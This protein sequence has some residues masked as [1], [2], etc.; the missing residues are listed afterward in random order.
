MARYRIEPQKQPNG[1]WLLA[2]LKPECRGHAF[3][4]HLCE[5]GNNTPASFETRDLARAGKKR[6]HFIDTGLANGQLRSREYWLDPEKEEPQT[7]AAA[8]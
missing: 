7:A 5:K 3:F 8:E 2:I 4:H 1:R 6:V